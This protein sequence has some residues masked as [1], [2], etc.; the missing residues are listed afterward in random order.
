MTKEERLQERINKKREQFLV[1]IGN[2]LKKAIDLCDAA[3]RYFSDEFTEPFIDFDLKN[4]I[5][6]ALE[7]VE[8]TEPSEVR[9]CPTAKKSGSD[10][11]SKL[12]SS[13]GKRR[14]RT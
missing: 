4:S 9:E 13:S 6:C 8:S 12:A 1:R 7:D 3:E 14:K 10:T 11:R 2:H 5:E